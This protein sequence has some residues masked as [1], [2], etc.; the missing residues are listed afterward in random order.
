VGC[1]QGRLILAG[2]KTTGLAVAKKSRMK[3]PLSLLHKQ[4]FEQIRKDLAAAGA[5]EGSFVR[6]EL[7]FF[8][9]LA[10]AKEYGSDEKENSLLAALRHVQRNEYQQ[11]KALFKKNTQ[12]ERVIARFI[13]CLKAVMSTAMKNGYS[14]RQVS[15]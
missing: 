11:T 5:K 12:R 10:M 13:K 15:P 6:V 4:Q 8:Q 7:L 9:A 3:E 14:H 1:Q 2:G